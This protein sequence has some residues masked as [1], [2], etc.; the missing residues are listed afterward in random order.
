VKLILSGTAPFTVS[1]GTA[2]SIGVAGTAVGTSAGAMLAAHPGVAFVAQLLP[3]ILT[4][5]AL[6]LQQVQMRERA[7]SPRGVE[8]RF[9]RMPYVA[10]VAIE[11]LLLLALRDA[12]LDARAW[13]VVAGVAVVTLLVLTRQ[14]IAFH[15]NDRLLTDLD[16]TMHDLRSQ[17]EWFRSLVQHASDITL[18]SGRTGVRYAGPA[19]E[20]VLGIPPSEVIGTRMAARLHPDDRAAADALLAKVLAR[21]GVQASAQLRLRHADGTYRWLDVIATDLRD[22]ASVGGVVFNARDVTVARHLQ[23]ELRY[24]A[25]HDTLTGLANRTLLQERLEAM[26]AGAPVSLAVLD[27][28]GFKQVNDAHG[29]HTGDALLTEVARRLTAA[30]DPDDL[31]VRIGGDEF[32]LLLPGADS[33]RAERVAERCAAVLREPVRAAGADLRVGASVGVASGTVAETARLLVQADAA[34]YTRKH[35]PAGRKAPAG[36]VLTGPGQ[37]P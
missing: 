15:D 31:A 2:G 9:S 1:A 14:L 25:T 26:P 33:D 28:D 23:E 34:M 8:R 21:P 24:R 11:G 29:H 16:R 37:V 30:L 13:G 19:V 12:G 35:G 3:C 20:R 32:A 4:A 6:R 7:G 17:E 22:N 36:I 5:A 10:V 18:V 27:L